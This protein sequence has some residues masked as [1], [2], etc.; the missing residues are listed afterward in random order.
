MKMKMVG[1]NPNVDR[2]LNEIV[3]KRKAAG[4]LNSTKQ[5]VIAELV[6]NQHKKECK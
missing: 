6:M 3:G 4:E 1:L 5:A 2:L